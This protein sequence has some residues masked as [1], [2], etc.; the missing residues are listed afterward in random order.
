MTMLDLFRSDQGKSA[1][2][3]THFPTTMQAIDDDMPPL[4]RTGADRRRCRAEPLY[5]R[6]G[7]QR[8]TG[9]EAHLLHLGMD[10]I[11]GRNAYRRNTQTPVMRKA[12]TAR[13][14]L[15]RT[16][17]SANT[18]ASVKIK[19]FSIRIRPGSITFTYSRT[20]TPN[21]P[22]RSAIKAPRSSCL[23]TPSTKRLFLRTAIFRPCPAN[24]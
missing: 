7:F 12:R 3:Y 23:E 19:S 10:R 8:Q 13:I 1:I 17:A 24:R 11:Q 6:R 18:G 20:R 16:W 9:R 15:S 4:P 22:T 5:R 2:E 21:A 14:G